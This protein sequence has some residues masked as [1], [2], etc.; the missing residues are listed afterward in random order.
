[1]CPFAFPEQIRG[2]I[3]LLLFLTFVAFP[4]LGMAQTPEKIAAKILSPLFVV[5]PRLQLSKGIDQR[6]PSY[7]SS[8]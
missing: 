8:C 4:A 1:M 7:S 3:R 6:M 2:V 5:L